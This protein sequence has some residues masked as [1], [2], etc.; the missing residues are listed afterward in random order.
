MLI[1]SFFV[2]H[3]MI[4]RERVGVTGLKAEVISY[5]IILGASVGTLVNLLPGYRSHL[6]QIY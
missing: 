4:W 3:A 5:N 6:A 2:L 1:S